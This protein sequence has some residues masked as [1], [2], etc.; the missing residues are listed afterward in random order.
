MVTVAKFQVRV[1]VARILGIVFVVAALILLGLDEFFRRRTTRRSDEELLAA[2]MH[3]LVV[4]V[5]SLGEPRQRDPIDIERFSYLARLAQFLERPI[6]YQLSGGQRTYAVDDELR[7]Y[8]YRPTEDEP[9][10]DRPTEDRPT[11]GARPD[12]TVPVHAPVRDTSRPDGPSPARRV[13]PTWSV[14]GGPECGRGGRGRPGRHP[15][16]QLHRQY[17]R[18][19]EQRRC[20]GA[21][22]TG[23]PDGSRRLPVAQPDPAGH[24]IR[25]F[26]NGLADALPLGAPA[27]T[28]SPTPAATA[29]SSPGVGSTRSPAWPPTS[30]SAD[31]R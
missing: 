18:P 14:R 31:P 9:T 2:K 19:G 22:P 11:E 26:S 15:D 10:E 23:V 21:G 3:V 16:H 8:R 13:R 1:S 25:V 7:Q 5:T 27:T 30:A 6:L 12:R 24:R 20:L 28:P 17:Q 4:P 29:A